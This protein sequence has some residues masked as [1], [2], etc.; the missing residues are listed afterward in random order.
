MKLEEIYRPDGGRKIMYNKKQKDITLNEKMLKRIVRT[1]I[2]VG[3]V[4]LIKK[5]VQKGNDDV[6]IERQKNRCVA[7]YP[8]CVHFANEKGSNICLNYFDVYNVLR[9]KVIGI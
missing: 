9:G 7:I 8:H 5:K 1:K 4:Y 2:K 6:S 3:K